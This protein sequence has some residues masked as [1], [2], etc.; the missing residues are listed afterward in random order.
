VL[1]DGAVIYS[2]TAAELA[3]DEDRVR[4]MAGAS[5]KE[6]SA[7][8]ESSRMLNGHNPDLRVASTVRDP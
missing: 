1:D 7:D 6:W 8:A 4:S 2:G 3:K 5:D